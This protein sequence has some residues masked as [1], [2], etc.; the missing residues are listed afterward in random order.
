MNNFIHIVDQIYCS[1]SPTQ[2]SHELT[3]LYLKSNDLVNLSSTEL[4]KS[5]KNNFENIYKIINDKS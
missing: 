3:M 2:I 4:A 1:P 5:Y